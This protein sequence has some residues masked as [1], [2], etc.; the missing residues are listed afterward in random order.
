[1]RVEAWITNR[2]EAHHYRSAGE[3]FTLCGLPLE[4]PTWWR[5]VEIGT[6]CEYCVDAL[7]WRRDLEV[8]A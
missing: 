1:M 4:Q 3:W 8:A 5:V 7:A 2:D 6:P